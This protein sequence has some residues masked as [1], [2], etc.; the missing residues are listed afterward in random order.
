MYVILKLNSETLE[1]IKKSPSNSKYEA[2]GAHQSKR[3]HKF[4]NL[5]SVNC[6]IG[7]I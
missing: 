3:D 1:E 6:K 2:D 5:N 7:I 4:R